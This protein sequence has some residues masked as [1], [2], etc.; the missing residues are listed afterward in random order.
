MR[1]QTNLPSI[2]VAHMMASGYK[3]CI[4]DLLDTR[5]KQFEG[6]LCGTDAYCK[7]G[8]TVGDDFITPHT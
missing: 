8:C 2:S 6:K 7:Y 5:E 4:D 1:H 3:R